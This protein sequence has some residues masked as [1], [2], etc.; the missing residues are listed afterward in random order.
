M[1]KIVS[2]LYGLRLMSFDDAIAHYDLSI[3]IC[4]STYRSP[5][6]FMWILVLPLSWNFLFLY[7]KISH[8]CKEK[9]N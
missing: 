6:S 9:L 8:N 5:F 7:Q 2:S 1:Y 4:A 3:Y